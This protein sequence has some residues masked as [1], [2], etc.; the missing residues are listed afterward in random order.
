[1]RIL[2]ILLL[3]TIASCGPESSP[4]GRLTTRLDAMQK[5]IDSLKAQ[6]R[7]VLDSLRSYKEAMQAP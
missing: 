4:E 2:L 1:M 7:I 5:D 6:N 3:A